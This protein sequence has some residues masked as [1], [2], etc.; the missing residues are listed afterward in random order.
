LNLAGYRWTRRISGFDLADG[1]GYDT[2][3]DQFNLRLD[4]N[5][6]ANHKLSFIYTWERDLDTTTQAGIAFW[7][8]GYY[9]ETGKDAC[10][11]QTRRPAR[12]VHWD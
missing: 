10:C 4:H 9:G 7:P 1:N 12:P 6:N 2:N 5:F 3:R 8:G 11:S